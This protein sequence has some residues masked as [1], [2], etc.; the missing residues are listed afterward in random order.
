MIDHFEHGPA[1]FSGVEHQI[2]AKM[3]LVYMLAASEGDFYK[4]GRTT[5]PRQRFSNIQTACPFEV[6]LIAGIRTPCAHL[7]ESH[8]HNQLLDYRTKGEWFKLPSSVADQLSNSFV[9][10]ARS[11]REAA[12]ALL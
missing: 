12:S 1:H 9:E 5:C 2:L 8:Y 3:E 7:V 6:S 10:S 11:A 4:I